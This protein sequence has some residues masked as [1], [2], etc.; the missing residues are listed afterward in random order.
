MTHG[1]Q[2]TLSY[3]STLF[4]SFAMTRTPDTDKGGGIDT[5]R[6]GREVTRMLDARRG[7]PGGKTPLGVGFVE[8]AG[9]KPQSGSDRHLRGFLNTQM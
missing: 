1:R 9:Q 2:C 4:S 5:E 6:R 3:K 8:P 7:H